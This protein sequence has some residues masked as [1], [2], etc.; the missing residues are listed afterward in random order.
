MSVFHVEAIEARRMLAASVTLSGG[1][2]T[3]TGTESA[4]VIEFDLRSATQLKVEVGSL[5]QKVDYSKVTKIVVNALGGND[6]VEFNQRNPITVGVEVSAGTGNDTVEATAG[7]DTLY[8]GGG[9]DFLDGREGSDSIFGE[10]GNDKL[11]GKGGNDSLYGGNGD[12][13]IQGQ[14]GD[15]LI[16]GNAGHDD[17]IGGSGRN[18]IR[19]NGGNDDFHADD[20]GRGEVEDESGDDKGR[21]ILDDL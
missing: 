15:D 1:V 13:Y 8:G 6:V 17:I 20:R 19:G 4:D 5:E 9:N 16:R 12:D 7:R 11:E 3:V 10:N 2:L 21:N 14:A 18:R